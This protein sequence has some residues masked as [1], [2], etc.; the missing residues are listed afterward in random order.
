MN[1]PLV[2]FVDSPTRV[3]AGQSPS[4]LDLV[5]AKTP[6]FVT[7][8][9]LEPPLGSSDHAVLQFNCN[10]LGRSNSGSRPKPNIWKADFVAMRR[11]ASLLPYPITDDDNV[12]QAWDKFMDYL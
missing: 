10:L 3:I 4:V 11:L 6:D 9:T 8:M 1:V 5:F 12:D 2:Q 7:V